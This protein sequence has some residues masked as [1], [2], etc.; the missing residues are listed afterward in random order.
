LE[1]T[2]YDSA[3]GGETAPERPTR[4]YGRS[5][6]SR[7]GERGSDDREHGGERGGARGGRRRFAPRRRV[8]TFCADKIDHIDYKEAELL[9]RFL[10]DRGK[11]KARRKTG[12]CAKHQ[13][14]LAIAIKRAR[15]IALLPFTGEQWR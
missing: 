13:R 8:C 7:G 2:Q 10:T 5:D 3:R 15:H 9:R 4:S 14:R 12:T 6:Y 11:I 1:D